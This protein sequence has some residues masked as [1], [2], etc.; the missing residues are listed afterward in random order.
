MSVRES[1]IVS[2]LQTAPRRRDD[3]RRPPATTRPTEQKGTTAQGVASGLAFGSILLVVALWA[4]NHGL[5]DLRGPA[6][7]SSVGRLTG[8]V[9]ADLL[10]IQVLLMARVPWIERAY[11]QDRLARSHRLVGFS[12]FNLMVAHI[13][14][15][16]VGYARVG[17]LGILRQAWDI[18]VSYPGMLLATA[19]TAMLVMVVVTSIRA[20][21]ARLRY[22]SWHL[23]HLYA[24]LG[25]G[26]ALPHEL[27]TGTDFIAQP[28][29]VAYW[30]T[31]YALAAGAVVVFRLALPLWRSARHGLVVERV[32]REAPGVVSIYLRGR[33]LPGL[34]I[35]AGHFLNWRFLNGPGWT[36][37]NPY[38]LSAAPGSRSLR[39]TVKDLGDGSR[40][41]A[42]LRPG[43]RALIE[44]PYGRLTADVRT[45]RRVTMLAS[46][47]GITPL[48]ALLEELRF[49]PG[50]AVL[51]YRATRAE[52]VLFRGEIDALAAKRG[53]EVR[54]LIG[55]RAHRA[56]WLPAGLGAIDDVSALHQLA[57]A[58]RT[59]DVFIC[60]PNGWMDA[61][62]AAVSALGVP[63]EQ[64]HVERF[65]W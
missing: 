41:L 20:A 40:T 47:I 26:L 36:R 60:G 59:S 14:L 1:G 37:A 35:R 39:I 28:L 46:G 15:I 16:T 54:Y 45:C 50:E 43:T 63:P 32:V 4:T 49:A 18:V 58:I 10:L 17:H 48:R 62:D 52:D 51:L 22:E 30:W 34:G 42:R 55:H 8:L 13:G 9:S 12:S 65:S 29:A 44:G 3:A 11:G 61:A 53:I 38:S 56:S 27:W 19:G 64:V 25:V 33:H 7:I 24:Y 23:L 21:R 57:P 6:A 5:R 31:L 2:T